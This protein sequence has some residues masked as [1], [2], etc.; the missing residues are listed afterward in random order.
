MIQDKGKL[1]LYDLGRDRD[2]QR[3]EILFIERCLD[4]LDETKGGRLGVVI[5]DGIL[6]NA[7]TQ[8]VRDFI[9]EKAIII[10]CVSLPDC[11]FVPA[12]SGVKASLLF[13]KKKKTSCEKQNPIFMALSE[14][15][16]YD[17]TG[18]PDTND[19]PT[20]LRRFRE[21]QEKGTVEPSKL[22]FGILQEN[23]EGRLDP[24]YYQ[25]YFLDA[26]KALEKSPFET[27]S[28]GEIAERITG[29][30]TPTA[31]G[32]SYTTAKGAGHPNGEKGIP[33]LRIQNVIENA[34]DLTNVEYI[35]PKI[36][37]TLLKRSQLKPNDILFTITGRIGTAAVVPKILARQTLI[38]TL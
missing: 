31:K 34:I 19:L 12:G 4:L 25:P 37:N 1:E 10:G 20:I 24:Y 13:L 2:R 7:S 33:F 38:S 30:A 5:P 6:T 22:G 23:L 28:L 16:G 21:F 29:G 27:K 9:Q 17:A 8:Y 15:V 26:L 3:T 14:H 36:H 32:N 18:R 11:T 35:I